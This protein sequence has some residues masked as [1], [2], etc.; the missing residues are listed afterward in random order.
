MAAGQLSATRL[1][2]MPKTFCIA[3]GSNHKP[4]EA[5]GSPVVGPH[6]HLFPLSARYIVNGAFHA[7]CS[8]MICP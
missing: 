7:C 5:M 4:Q 3:D 2:G 6:L 8:F 1:E